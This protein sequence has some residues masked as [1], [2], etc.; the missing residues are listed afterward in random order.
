MFLGGLPVD[1]CAPMSFKCEG[2]RARVDDGDF[3]SDSRHLSAGLGMCRLVVYK[4][5]EVSLEDVLVRPEHNIVQ[6]S[7][8]ASYHPGC[9]S[10][11]N[12]RVNGDGFGVAW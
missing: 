12:Y 7:R 10:K 9:T 8:D 2:C 3:K 1:L 6:Q 4:G 5:P 11:R